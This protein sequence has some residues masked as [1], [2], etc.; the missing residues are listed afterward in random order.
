MLAHSLA[1]RVEHV[2]PVVRIAG[3]RVVA[4][5]AGEAVEVLAL[6]LERKRML[7]ARVVGVELRPQQR[8]GSSASTGA[9]HHVGAQLREPR[10]AHR[11]IVLELGIGEQRVDPRVRSRSAA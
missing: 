10:V 9:L 3:L 4:A 8:P 2:V 7:H 1:H 11:R 6:V 5:G